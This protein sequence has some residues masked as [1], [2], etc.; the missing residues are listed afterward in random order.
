[1]MKTEISVLLSYSLPQIVN[2]FM[3]QIFLLYWIQWVLW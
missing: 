2:N 3:G 1:M